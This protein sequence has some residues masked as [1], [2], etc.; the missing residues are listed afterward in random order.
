MQRRGRHGSRS[1]LML[2]LPSYLIKAIR[3]NASMNS[4]RVKA[5]TGL[6]S[7]SPSSESESLWEG[8]CL[9]HG[10]VST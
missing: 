9:R 7:A 4:A 2:L 6:N 10:F 3:I 8:I 1:E 5:L